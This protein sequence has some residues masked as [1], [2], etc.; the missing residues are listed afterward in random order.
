MPI[1]AL[2]AA[3]AGFASA[4]LHAVLLT[5]SF[6]A[7]IL[8]YLAQLPLFMVGLWMGATSAVIAALTGAIA[9]AA[10]GGFV[11]AVAYLLVNAVPAV[12]ITYLAQH[13]RQREDGRRVL[14]WEGALPNGDRPA[15]FAS[16]RAILLLQTDSAI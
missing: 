9:L 12:L 15:K 2:V 6:G 10:G 16:D 14:L 13:N 11:F 3:G 4:A 1:F 8:A 7:I 5:G